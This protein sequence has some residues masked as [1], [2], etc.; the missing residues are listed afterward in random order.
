MSASDDLFRRINVFSPFP[1]QLEAE[2][3]CI[4]KLDNGGYA[5]V[6]LATD[7][8]I[9]R[10]VAVKVF[11][12]SKTSAAD[13]V[14]EANACADIQ[15]PFVVTILDVVNESACR[16]IIMEFVGEF[17]DKNPSDRVSSPSSAYH[18]RPNSIREALRWVKGAAEG[19]SAAHRKS[20]YHRDIK[21]RNL[22]ITP[23]S[24]DPKL[25]DFGLANRIHGG[26]GTISHMAP[27]QTRIRSPG[28]V[29]SPEQDIA[30]DVFGLGAL[31]Y[32]LLSGFH[33]FRD[34]EESTALHKASKCN[35]TP[36]HRYDFVSP[37]GKRER[38]SRRL[39]RV[40]HE[41]LA[42]DWRDR[43]KT[44]DLFR[45][46][47]ELWEK[48]YTVSPDRFPIL[49]G[50][51]LWLLRHWK[52]VTVAV[53]VVVVLL[54]MVKLKQEQQAS[55]QQLA[56]RQDQLFELKR[57]IDLAKQDLDKTRAL[58]TALESQNSDILHWIADV[59]H[60]HNP[61][62]LPIPE[63]LRPIFETIYDAAT[64]EGA[65]ERQADRSEV[66]YKLTNSLRACKDA[67]QFIPL[68]APD[69]RYY[70]AAAITQSVAAKEL[71]KECQLANEYA[72]D[73]AM[74]SSKSDR[75]TVWKY[76]R[77]RDRAKS[78]DDGCICSQYD[79][80][81]YTDDGRMLITGINE[82]FIFQQSNSR[83][84]SS[85][86]KTC[87]R[88]SACFESK[89]SDFD[90]ATSAYSRMALAWNS[91]QK[92]D[93]FQS[94]SDR[95]ACS[96]G[97]SK[98]RDDIASGKRGENFDKGC[99]GRDFR[100]P[101]TEEPLVRSPLELRFIP[102]RASKDQQG[103]YVCDMALHG[104]DEAHYILMTKTNER[105]LVSG[106]AVEHGAL[107]RKEPYDWSKCTQLKADR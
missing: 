7:R 43:P 57:E 24:R 66:V 75:V 76:R 72:L 33:P 62:S 65:R 12:P 38:I 85:V 73:I 94:F 25:T 86:D 98:S 84:S 9:N 83:E 99:V 81:P 52:Y 61:S 101:L 31:A 29:F 104:S 105:W 28:E 8:T 97:Q 39:S 107:C 3:K 106:E 35:L 30:V 54:G 26:V 17:D 59:Q 2:Y 96:F 14:K 19:V 58:T 79:I 6:W 103:F 102:D 23:F 41:A 51:A 89:A 88:K 64:Q 70:H 20:I 63:S 5:T 44:A 53:T 67:S 1:Q 80:G 48:N 34:T 55:Q 74:T 4:R 50:F 27:E 15:N 100:D 45:Q 95:L 69:V 16:A 21:P 68:L 47:L 32:D 40:I 18:T 11:D 46:Q 42:K 82:R 22:L 71:L 90:D 91:C 93:F 92:E 10:P 60:G 56:S 87:T 49:M 36:L 13:I 78:A 37:S 77:Q